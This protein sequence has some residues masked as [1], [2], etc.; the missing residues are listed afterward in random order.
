LQMHQIH[1]VKL[2]LANSFGSL[3]NWQWKEYLKNER[4]IAKS[5]IQFRFCNEKKLGGSRDW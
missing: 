4:K 1:L 5:E 3:Q 2:W